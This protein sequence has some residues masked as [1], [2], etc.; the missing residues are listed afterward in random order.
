M[1]ERFIQFVVV[2]AAI[3][4]TVAAALLVLDRS[5]GEESLDQRA[6]SQTM[7]DSTVTQLLPEIAKIGQE[8]TKTVNGFLSLITDRVDDNRLRRR[9]VVSAFCDG[10]TTTQIVAAFGYERKRVEAIV[11]DNA[12]QEEC[13][14]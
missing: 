14:P 8:L 4:A 12:R 5:D 1:N 9:D 10:K 7:V 3:A 6:F 13:S 11:K 2:V